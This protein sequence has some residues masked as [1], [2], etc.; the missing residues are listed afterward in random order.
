[1]PTPA[2]R[3]ISCAVTSIPVSATAARAASTSRSMLRRASARGV[4]PG[5]AASRAPTA[6]SLLLMKALYQADSLRPVMLAS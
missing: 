1:M 5:S 2:L 3:A 4:R 6:P